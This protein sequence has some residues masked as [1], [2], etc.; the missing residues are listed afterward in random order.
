MTLLWV[1]LSKHGHHLLY[2]PEPCTVV[3]VTISAA[4]PHS[5]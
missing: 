5:V 4:S 1:D 2:C 3:R